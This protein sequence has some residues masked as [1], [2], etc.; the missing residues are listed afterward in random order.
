MKIRQQNIDYSKMIRRINLPTNSN[1]V[2][3]WLNN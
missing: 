3:V 2:D 1:I